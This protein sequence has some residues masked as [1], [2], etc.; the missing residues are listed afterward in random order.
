MIWIENIHLK[1]VQHEKSLRCFYMCAHTHT[2]TYTYHQFIIY[3]PI[4]FLMTTKNIK[5][6]ENRSWRKM[7]KCEIENLDF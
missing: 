7:F 4:R 3:K 2:L 5:W 1:S 6:K